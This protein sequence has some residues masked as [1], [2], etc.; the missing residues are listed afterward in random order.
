[1]FIFVVISRVH[2]LLGFLLSVRRAAVCRLSFRSRR[3]PE[4]KGDTAVVNRNRPKV[5]L[6]KILNYD[7]GDS[8]Q[9]QLLDPPSFHPARG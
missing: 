6:R 1:M 2:C 4:S 5:V 7:K 3:A 8:E 9:M